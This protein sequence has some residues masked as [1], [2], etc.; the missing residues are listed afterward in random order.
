MFS[1]ISKKKN[2]TNF[3]NKKKIK[4]IFVISGRNSFYKSGAY[5]IINKKIIKKKI[6]FYFKKS[7]LPEIIEL[8][9]I[10][11]LLHRFNPDL[12]IAVGGGTVLDYAKIAHIADKTKLEKLKSDI[13]KFRSIGKSKT[14]PLLAIPTTAGSGAEVTS[15]AVIYINK[16]KF[17]VENNLLIPSF[18]LLIPDFVIKNPHKIKSSSAFDAI[19]QALESIISRKSNK[20]SIYYAKK[21]LK[22]SCEHNLSFLK[23]PTKK[24][25]S[26]MLLAANFSGKAINISQTTAPHALSYPFSY[27]FNM[28]HGHAVS[29]TLEKFLEFNYIN[30]KKSKNFYDLKK[31]YKVIFRIFKVENISQLKKKIIL[32]KKKMKLSSNLKNMRIDINKNLNKILSGI[33]YRRLKNNPVRV[34]KKDIKKI[35]LDIK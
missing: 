29:L 30:L 18:F 35:L 32:I 3:I 11:K 9:K 19:S 15:G 31:K 12:I 10:I 2:L 27:Y 5:K 22:L 6:Q 20:A 33:N 4:K 7:Y 14:Y 24:N 34:Y 17:S 26:N 21:S 1:R 25:C 8:K 13:V 23:N 28:P 16:K